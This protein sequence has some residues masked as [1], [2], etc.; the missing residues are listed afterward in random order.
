MAWAELTDVRCFY[1]LHGSGEPV[2]FIAGLGGNCELWRPAESLS[3]K[4]TLLFPDNRGIGQSVARRPAHT[5]ADYTSDMIELLD[6]LQLERAHVVGLSLGGIIAQRLAIDHPS[7]IDRLVLI[8]TVHRST[9]YLQCVS[10]LLAMAL[11]RMPWEFFVR[12]IETLGTAPNFVDANPAEIQRRID[13]KCSAGVLRE[14]VAQ[15]LQC[16][17]ADGGE[18]DVSRIAA[19]TLVIAGEH[20]A[21]IPAHYAEAM[22]REIPGSRFHLIASAGHNP[23]SECPEKVIEPIA[24]FL[25]QGRRAARRLQPVGVESM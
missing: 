12:T 4:F 18:T 13:A 25:A 22:A 7:R 23:L 19:P 10:A 16:L 1:E 17:A 8:S 2:L 21:L 15:Q 9:P 3:E 6:H 11:R 5:L 20:D 14:A 24:H